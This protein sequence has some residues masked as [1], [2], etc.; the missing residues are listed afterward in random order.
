MI[1]KIIII[2]RLPFDIFL[3]TN[4]VEDENF[5]KETNEICSKIKNLLI[6]YSTKDLKKLIENIKLSP[7]EIFN[8]EEQ[9]YGFDLEDLEN[10]IEGKKKW[11]MDYFYDED[12]KY[13]ITI[14]V[15]S[16]VVVVEE[17]K[18]NKICIIFDEILFK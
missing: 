5:E 3:W 2:K 6:K 10:F 14:D 13:E 11:Y 15:Y 4:T 17:C 9:L 8:R 16:R 18:K 12:V 7:W 1:Q